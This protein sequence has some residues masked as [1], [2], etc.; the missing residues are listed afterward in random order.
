M[1]RKIL[2]FYELTPLHNLHTA[3]IRPICLLIK[4][5]IFLYQLLYLIRMYYK[6]IILNYGI[7]L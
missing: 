7:I 4:Q 5:A 2:R 1:S 3:D 6:R